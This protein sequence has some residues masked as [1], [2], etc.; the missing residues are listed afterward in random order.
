L[1]ESAKARAVLAGAP[2]TITKHD[3][4][5]AWPKNGRCPALGIRLQHG[6]RSVQDASP[7][8]D[9]LNGDWGYVPGN[10]AVISHAANRAKGNMTAR[11]LAGIAAWMRRKGLS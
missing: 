3:I 7:T 6:T 2:F 11:Q 4:A 9:R 8:L 10:I 5:A 1:Y